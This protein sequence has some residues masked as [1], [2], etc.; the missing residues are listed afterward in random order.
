[1]V[2]KLIYKN[3]DFITF[4]MR[5][6]PLQSSFSIIYT[7]LNA[8]MPAYETVALANFIDCA[9]DIFRGK[10]NN[11]DIVFPIVMIVLYILFVNLMPSISNI[12]SITGKSKLTVKMKDLILNKRA[13]LEYMHIE[14]AETQELINRVCSD[15]VGNFLSGFN[16]ILSAASIIIS[17]I[18]LL[19]IIMSSTF[20]SGIVIVIISIPLFAIAM[21]T[22]KKN[23]EMSKE[24]RKIQ[25][26]YGYLSDVLTGRDYANERKLF[27]F[28]KSMQNDYDDLYVQSFKIESKIEKKTYTNMKSG[29]MVTLAVIA[30]IVSVLLPSLNAGSITL[31]VFVALVNA[32]FSLVQ[33]MSW[34]LSGIM[35]EYS[36]LQEY[37]K[38]LNSFLALSEKKEACVE[39]SR[40]N[41]F[42]FESLE[43]R[44]VSFKYPGT[45]NYVLNKCSF[46]LNSGKSYSFVGI[47]GAGK[48]TIAKLII[49]LYDDYEGEILLNGINIKQYDYATI[50]AI[51]SVLFQDFTTY[52]ISMKDN[53][54]IG[55]DMIYNKE[56]VKN[57]IS[58]AGLED[59]TYELKNNIE[60]SL[61]KIKE[62]G[63]D[64][65]GGQWQRIAI[66]RLLYSEAKI[67][68]LDEPTASLDPAAESQLYEMF[69]RINNNRFTIYITHRLGA[70]K[71]SDEILV[72]DGG[73]IVE[74]GSHEK[75]MRMHDGLYHKMFNSQK[76]WYE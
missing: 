59:L 40:T 69:H 45:E 6:I 17:S 44:N 31:G 47:N 16:N 27:G 74:S 61:G 35:S 51:I 4:P 10:R 76:S 21:R 3:I 70:A 65:S 22:G 58:Q 63:V 71:I 14:N 24:A 54:T 60:T 23:Y 32:V 7:I 49:G 73:K 37:L 34:Q 12:I 9:M 52:A 72:V 75:L 20:I 25:R 28:S 68:I 18:S 19:A 39:P 46:L 36:R 13:S 2:K 42:I 11:A 1:M 53:I 56:E 57:I 26:R 41:D 30:V 43:F 29:S 33:T 48:S 38:D 15:P 67:N 62:D 50:K 8:L 5:C 64:V 66:G 55:R